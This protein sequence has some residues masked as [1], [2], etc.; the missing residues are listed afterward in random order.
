VTTVIARLIPQLIPE[1]GVR[2]FVQYTVVFI[3]LAMELNATNCRNIEVAGL[4]APTRP[5]GFLPGLN[6]GGS[7]RPVGPSP[8]N[9]EWT[10]H[11]T[12]QVQPARNRNCPWGSYE[13]MQGHLNPQTSRCC[14]EDFLVPKFLFTTPCHFFCAVK[15]STTVN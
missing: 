3:Q 2:Y 7:R 1:K 5:R 9:S 10:D 15:P 13:T 6:V 4:E 14:N 11:R 12:L 8:P